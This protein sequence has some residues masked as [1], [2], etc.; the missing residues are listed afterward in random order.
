MQKRMKKNKGELGDSFLVQALKISWFK[1]N[2]DNYISGGTLSL[3]HGFIWWKAHY[4]ISLG[5]QFVL[6]FHAI[7]LIL[8]KKVFYF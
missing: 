3:S 4:S 7:I 5:G 6:F 1:L 2:N 8:P